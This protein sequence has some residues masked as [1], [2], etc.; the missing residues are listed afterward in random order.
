[1]ILSLDWL[2]IE[3]SDRRDHWHR[4]G[5]PR[6]LRRYDLRHDLTA[7]LSKA[8]FKLG[9]LIGS[10]FDARLTFELVDECEHV[11]FWPLSRGLF[12]HVVV[13]GRVLCVDDRIVR[14]KGYCPA[15]DRQCRRLLLLAEE[16]QWLLCSL[17]VVWLE[18]LARLF[19]YFDPQA[20]VR[21]DDAVNLALDACFIPVALAAGTDRSK[22]LGQLARNCLVVG[23]EL[24]PERIHREFTLVT[25]EPLKDSGSEIVAILEELRAI[26]FFKL[27]VEHL[28]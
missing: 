3:F 25:V 17:V 28:E 27:V 15:P 21:L 7:D 6:L 23:I 19:G 9:S 8:F 24:F 26:R 18:F 14:D 1:M 20:Y 4:C 10:Q 5:L 22:A 2:W 11:D 16:A 12:R 13:A